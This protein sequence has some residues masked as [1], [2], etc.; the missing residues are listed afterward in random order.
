M[1]AN[2]EE[3]K[4]KLVELDN[5]I[6]KKSKFNG[7]KLIEE[8]YYPMWIVLDHARSLTRK[9]S[10]LTKEIEQFK[11]TAAFKPEELTEVKKSKKRYNNRRRK[12]QKAK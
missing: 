11:K 3:L 1:I 6:A 2:T 4:T 7:H 8:N 9:V 5:A 10:E 12:S